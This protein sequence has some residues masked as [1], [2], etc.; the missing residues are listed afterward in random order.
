VERL[1]WEYV[2]ILDD[3]FIVVDSVY[4]GYYAGVGYYLPMGSNGAMYMSFMWDFSYDS[5]EP[6][7][8]PNPWLI[9]IGYGVTF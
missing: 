3:Q 4:T 7:P 5:S 9:R 2:G 6:S 1:N 8:N